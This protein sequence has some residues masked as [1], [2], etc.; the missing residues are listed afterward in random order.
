MI[1]C[2]HIHAIIILYLPFYKHDSINSKTYT[3]IPVYISRWL[4]VYTIYISWWLYKHKCTSNVYRASREPSRAQRYSC[5]RA[6]T[7]KSA[8][9]VILVPPYRFVLGFKRQGYQ[10]A[11]APLNQICWKWLFGPPKYCKKWQFC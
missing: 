11:R 7:A 4:Y 5:T 8:P 1:W 6:P 9:R 10:F 2:Q 3:F